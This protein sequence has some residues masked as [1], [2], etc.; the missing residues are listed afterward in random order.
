MRLRLVTWNCKGRWDK[1]YDHIARLRPDLAVIQECANP[2]RIAVPGIGPHQ[3][4]GYLD[5][6]DP[7]RNKTHNPHNGI[8]VFSWTGLTLDEQQVER[9]PSIRYVWPLRISGPGALQLHVL[10]VWNKRTPLV[11][12]DNISDYVYTLECL[13]NAYDAFIGTPAVATNTIIIGDFNTSA[14]YEDDQKKKRLSHNRM[15]D[16]FQTL[17]LVN[18][19]HVFPARRR[20]GEDG[21][22][23]THR[24]NSPGKKKRIL[25][26]DYCFIP[27]RWAE[28]VRNVTLGEYGD[29]DHRPVIVDLDI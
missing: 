29:S 25:H 6:H 22:E 21:E 24:N 27:D 11:P 7:E 13:M 1:N 5:C 26:L 4:L 28:R 17:G 20:H 3:C 18:A 10:A 23:P 2:C 12:G 8:G 16:R 19:Y 15:V 9:D 14:A